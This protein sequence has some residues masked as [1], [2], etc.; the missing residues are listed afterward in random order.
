MR[1]AVRL[2][3]QDGGG[4]VGECQADGLLGALRTQQIKRRLIDVAELHIGPG[5]DSRPDGRLLQ[6]ACSRLNDCS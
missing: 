4:H 3:C 1:G 2:R 5:G 6:T